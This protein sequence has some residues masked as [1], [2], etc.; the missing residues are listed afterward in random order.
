MLRTSVR[1]LIIVGC[2]LIPVVVRAQITQIGDDTS[3]PIAGVGHDYIKM[4][5]ETVNP[6]NGSV[7]LRIQV[8]V[9]KG[10]GITVPFSF[11]YDSNGV[12]HL[13][14]TAAGDTG[15]RSNTSYLA[16][17]GWSY[18][19]PQ[20]N[21]SA[22]SVQGSSGPPTNNTWTCYYSVNFMLQDASGGRHPIRRRRGIHRLR[23]W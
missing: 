19:V 12:N 5:D 11:D 20:L 9:P 2:L 3:V 13:V 21:S 22:Y 4:L 7:S 1:T 10:R 17:G 23:E 18:G 16:Q 14:G 6:A 15:W 8:P